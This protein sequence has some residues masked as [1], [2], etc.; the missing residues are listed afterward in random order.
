LRNDQAVAFEDA[1][2]GRHRRDL[3][4]RSRQVEVDGLRSGVMTGLGQLAAELDDELLDF[5]LDLV[6][7]RLRSP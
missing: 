1:P 5:G 6:R 3:D 4:Q 7:A 2:D